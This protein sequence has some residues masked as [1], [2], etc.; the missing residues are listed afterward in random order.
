[1]HGYVL[2]PKGFTF[3]FELADDHVGVLSIWSQS[4]EMGKGEV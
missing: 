2:M 4:L 1:L 3:F